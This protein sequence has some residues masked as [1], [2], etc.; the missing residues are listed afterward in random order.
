LSLCGHLSC[1]L[2]NCDVTMMFVMMWCVCVM[3]IYLPVEWRGDTSCRQWHASQ[4]LAGLDGTMESVCELDFCHEV[5]KF[6]VSL[7]AINE[8]SLLTK[9]QYSWAQSQSH[10]LWVMGELL[11]RD[12]VSSQAAVVQAQVRHVL[13]DL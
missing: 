1:W 4:C 6:Q 8:R 5:E 13:R 11:G 12:S 7:L 9:D 10:R 2:V 3:P